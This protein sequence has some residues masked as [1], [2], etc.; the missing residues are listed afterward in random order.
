MQ[1][2]IKD[3]NLKQ[4]NTFVPEATIIYIVIADLI[5]ISKNFIPYAMSLV[6]TVKYPKG[7]AKTTLL[8]KATM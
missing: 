8:L 6:L 5:H 1:W 3:A 2:Y 7:R 4:L